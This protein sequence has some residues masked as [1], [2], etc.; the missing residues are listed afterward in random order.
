MPTD[1]KTVI[2]ADYPEFKCPKCAQS[3]N[4]IEY[5]IWESSDG[6]YEDY[7]YNCILCG[8]DWWVESVDY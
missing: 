7:H 1:K 5:Y 4:S 3:N 8:H 6:A 2:T